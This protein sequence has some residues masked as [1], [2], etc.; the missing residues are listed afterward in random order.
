M[1]KSSVAGDPILKP[2]WQAISHR[3]RDPR[4][5]AQL[6]D[7]YLL[8]RDLADRLRNTPAG[9]RSAAYGPLYDELFARLPHHP[10]HT[11]GQTSPQYTQKQVR[12]LKKLMPAGASFLEIGAGDASLSI[13]MTGLCRQVT[14]LDVSAKLAPQTGLPPNF[15]FALTDGISIPL[16]SGSVEFA[17]SNQLMEHLHPDDVKLQLAEIYRVLAPGGRYFCITPSRLTGPHDISRYFDRVSRGFHLVEYSFSDCRRLFSEVGF[18][19]FRA[20]VTRSGHY[21]GAMPVGFAIAL[22]RL[23]TS[24]PMPLSDRLGR[25]PLVRAVLGV[26][27]VATKPA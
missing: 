3:Y 18:R 22:E 21:A 25:S 11:R 20:C 15:R 2:N 6:I 16:E 14:A 13:A 10:Q 24:L 23:F 12:V 27:I 7:N 9:E 26:A 5:A 4:Q 17:Y 19:G 8:E 1:A